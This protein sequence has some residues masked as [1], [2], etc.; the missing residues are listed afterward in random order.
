MEN[1]KQKILDILKKSGIL[2][3]SFCAFLPLLPYLIECRAKNRL[4]KDAK[5]VIPCIFPYKVFDIPPKNISRYSAVPD[6]H[7]VLSKYLSSATDNLRDEFKDYS[8]EF[9]I[10]NSPIPEVRAA[11]LAGLGVRGDNGLL[12]N[13]KY[14]SFIFIGE[15]VT[16]LEI[17]CSE[18]YNECLHCGKCKSACPKKDNIECLS[19]VTQKKGELS[20]LEISAIK[21][22][23]T[24][25]G[26]DICSEVCPLNENKERTY[27]PEFIS[28]Y[29][30]EYTENENISG[31]AFEWRGEKV[32]KR[33]YNYK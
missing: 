17:E 32:I 18:N 28:G 1:Q 29:R 16:D 20:E 2:D 31:R 15:I 13:E 30:N 9:F 4:P 21:K 10:D 5:T 25:W 7:S 24:I 19:R 6:Y 3:A 33:N 12:I 11:V 26:C 14:G 22:Y 23:G 8:F 27:L